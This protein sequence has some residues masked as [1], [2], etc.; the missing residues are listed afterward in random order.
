M[1][2]SEICERAGEW[3]P[4]TVSVTKAKFFEGFRKPLPSVYNVVVQELLVQQHLIRYNKKYQYD[5][6]GS[7][8]T[9]YRYPEVICSAS[10][11]TLVGSAVH[12]FIYS[13]ST[14]V[15]ITRV[16]R[17]GLHWKIIQAI[18]AGEKWLHFLQVFAL[19]FVSVFDQVLDGLPESGDTSQIFGAY[20]SALDEDASKYREDHDR[21]AA[22]AK[23]LTKSSELTPDDSGN[24]VRTCENTVQ[25][26]R[27]Q[28][29][30]HASWRTEL[31]PLYNSLNC[32]PLKVFKLTEG[33]LAFDMLETAYS[34]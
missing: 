13:P 16:Q 3:N 6:V 14:L 2:I 10:Y 24:E 5:E 34:S 12:I 26:D 15:A 32:L 30:L 8:L 28:A 9:R 18:I 33:L 4:P 11:F 19:G 31:D 25:E 20:I 21:L 23:E 7:F 22:Q 27:Q 29:L 17:K 1:H